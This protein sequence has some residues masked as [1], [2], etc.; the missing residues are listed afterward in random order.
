MATQSH[1][2]LLSEKPV[3]EYIGN[4]KR[5]LESS[6]RPGIPMK[7]FIVAA[8]VL[9]VLQSADAMAAEPQAGEYVR[10]LRYLHPLGRKRSFATSPVLST[11]ARELSSER[12]GTNCEAQLAGW[13]S[14]TSCWR[15]SS[16]WRIT[17][18]RRKSICATTE[19]S[20]TLSGLR[21]ASMQ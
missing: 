11:T 18:A 17:A 2:R 3:G 7:R 13:K 10:H 15:C 19:F 4:R 16:M 21:C 9:A 6:P 20:A 5:S 1:G 12:E 14:G 8:L